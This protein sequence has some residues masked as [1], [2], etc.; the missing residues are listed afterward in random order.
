MAK[1]L[2]LLSVMLLFAGLPCM[3][4]GDLRDITGSVTDKRGNALPGA[5]VQLENT[6]TLTVMSYITGKDGGYH[7]NGL[8]SDIDYTVK[9]KYRKFWSERKTLSKFSSSKHP[10]IELVIPID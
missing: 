6:V 8:Q 1:R 10:Q 5:A 9:A 4:Q 7:F 3:A 2:A